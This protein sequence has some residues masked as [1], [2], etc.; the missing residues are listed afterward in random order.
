[1]DGKKQQHIGP[2]DTLPILFEC[3]VD[4]LWNNIYV[5]MIES[6]TREISKKSN[7]YMC[8]MHRFFFANVSM[9]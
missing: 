1:M 4:N 5:Y 9:N 2:W 3:M 8:N 6:G 7:H